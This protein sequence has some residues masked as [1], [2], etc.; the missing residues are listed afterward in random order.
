MLPARS[1]A[2]A[3]SRNGPGRGGVNPTLV[4]LVAL[5]WLVARDASHVEPVTGQVPQRKETTSESAEFLVTVNV[6]DSLARRPFAGRKSVDV[7]VTCFGGTLSTSAEHQLDHPLVAP[8][9]S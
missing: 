3:T 4:E 5:T 2:T 6:P 8:R 7:T 1:I 9:E